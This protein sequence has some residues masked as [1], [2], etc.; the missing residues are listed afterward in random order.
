MADEVCGGPTKDG[1]ACRR[2]PGCSIQ[3]KGSEKERSA[4]VPTP[5]PLARM[6]LG[7]PETAAC[8]E[9]YPGL[10]GSDDQAALSSHPDEFV[11]LVD[12]ACDQM[13]I[14]PQQAVRDYYLH[15]ALRTAVS[16]SPPDRPVCDPSD[17]TPVAV[18]AFGGGTSLTNAHAVVERYSED[19]DLVLIPLDPGVGRGKLKRAR[20]AFLRLIAGPAAEAIGAEVEFAGKSHVSHAHFSI[21]GFGEFLRVDVAHQP[22]MPDA[23]RPDRSQSLMGR[24]ATESERDAWPELDGVAV[25]LVSVEVTAVNKLLTLHHAAERRQDRLLAERARDLYDLACIARGTDSPSRLRGR[26]AEL[27]EILTASGIHKRLPGG[28]RPTGGL[29]S[30]IV[31]RPDCDAYRLLKTAYEQ[32]VPRL[33]WGAWRPGFEE[34]VQ[35]AASLDLE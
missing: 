30:S 2:P 4:G 32:E 18:W 35:L 33:I 19:L 26:A 12:A 34:A 13:N 20:K 28:S 15:T 25:P 1:A 14:S 11:A 9:K 17:G 10:G 29:G 23:V 24:S 3:H 7:F 16:V 31:F 22:D 6:P 5:P 27:V 8:N 21:D